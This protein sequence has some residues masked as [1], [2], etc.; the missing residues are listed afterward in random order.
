MAVGHQRKDAYKNI[1]EF[2]KWHVTPVQKESLSWSA[3]DGTEKGF[4]LWDAAK[5]KTEIK[6]YVWI[7]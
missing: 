7:T 6:I 3:W 1:L 2:S 4:R 5:R